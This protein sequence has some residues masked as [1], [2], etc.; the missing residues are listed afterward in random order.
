MTELV[1]N[2]G[3]LLELQKTFRPAKRR[4]IYRKTANNKDDSPESTPQPTVARLT[5]DELVISQGLLPGQISASE[6]AEVP[7]AEIL[8]QRR[9]VQRRKGGIEFTNN[10]YGQ[11]SSLNGLQNSK[12]LQGRGESTAD[13]EATVNRFAPQTGQVVNADKHM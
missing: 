12:A 10:G 1:A 8:R 11:K 2:D 9:Y 7:V 4:K 5:L 6:T 3:P 13:L